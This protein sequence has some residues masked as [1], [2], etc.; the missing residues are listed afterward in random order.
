MELWGCALWSWSRLPPL[1]CGTPLLHRRNARS[2]HCPQMVTFPISNIVSVESTCYLWCTLT[3][4]CCAFCDR[5]PSVQDCW[6]SESLQGCVICGRL[7]NRMPGRLGRKWDLPVPW[8]LDLCPS[9]QLSASLSV[10]IPWPGLGYVISCLLSSAL[11]GQREISQFSPWWSK[12]TFLLGI[13]VLFL[14]LIF[15]FLLPLVVGA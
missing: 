7:R 12:H 2:H 6:S 11:C 4:D 3:Q 9:A 5:A 1:P 13:S 15:S 14:F 8:W 10:S